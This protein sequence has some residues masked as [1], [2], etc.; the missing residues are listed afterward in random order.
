MDR[1]REEEREEEQKRRSRGLRDKRRVTFISLLVI[2]N[3]VTCPF[4]SGR[5]VQIRRSLQIG[6]SWNNCV[7]INESSCMRRTKRREQDRK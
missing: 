1:R 7:T 3:V 2:P 6:N 4:L 5:R